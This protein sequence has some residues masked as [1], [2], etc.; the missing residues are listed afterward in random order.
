[1]NFDALRELQVAILITHALTHIILMQAIS[2][3]ELNKCIL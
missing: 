2:F 1:M 3:V